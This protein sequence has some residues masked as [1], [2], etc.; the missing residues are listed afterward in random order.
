MLQYSKIV[1]PAL[2]YAPPD[3]LP[4]SLEGPDQRPLRGP[5]IVQIFH[6]DFILAFKQPLFQL[7]LGILQEV[8]D[9]VPILEV[10]GKPL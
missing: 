7:P 5:V 2:N 9:D 10:F 6:L 1:K 8:P 4:S 3:H